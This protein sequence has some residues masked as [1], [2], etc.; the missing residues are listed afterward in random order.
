MTT[1]TQHLVRCHITFM[2]SGV[3]LVYQNKESKSLHRHDVCK[4]VVH[5][6]VSKGRPGN[7]PPEMNYSFQIC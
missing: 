2:C 5:L 6:D 3:T 7:F 4:T 1:I